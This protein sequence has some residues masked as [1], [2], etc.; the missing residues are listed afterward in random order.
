MS[1]RHRKPTTSSISVAKIAFT[2]AVLG[3]G[4]IAMAGQA[5]AATDGEWD[6]VA[7][8]ESGGNWGINTGNGYYGGVQFTAST[9]AAHG[10]GQYAPS[11]QLATREQQIAVAERVLAT[12]GRGAWP[13]CGGP[14][15]G[16]TPREVPTPAG[17]D[18][19]LDAPGINGE[20]APLAPPP[21]D[22]PPPDAPPPPPPPPPADPPPVRLASFDQPAPPA[23]VP[24]APP[25]DV[26]PPPADAAPPAPADVPPPRA[27][28]PP[29]PADVPPPPADVP[30]PP[31]GDLN[32]APAEPQHASTVGF[33]R[34]LWDAIQATDIHGNDALDA[35]AQPSPNG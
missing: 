35:L 17:M 14:L 19:P 31:P 22:A 30:P 8:C 26:A 4:S 2:G 15:S 18:A 16:P 11:A 10:G 7:R 21:A 34:Q 24:P 5:A 28:V 27:D 3:G 6:Q 32:A 23:D 12:Q 25:A 1:G 33:T 20:P 9:W 29:P 13:V